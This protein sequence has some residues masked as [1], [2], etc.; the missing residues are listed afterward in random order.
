VTGVQP[1]VGLTARRALQSWL[2]VRVVTQG[3]AMTAALGTVLAACT[4]PRPAVTSRAATVA[5]SRPVSPASTIPAAVSAVL[6]DQLTVTFTSLTPAGDDLGAWLT[7]EAGIDN[8]SAHHQHL[9]AIGIRCTG[10]PTLGGHRAVASTLSLAGSLPAHSTRHGTLFLL[11]PGDRRRGR[12]V[13]ACQAPA[14]IQVSELPPT[15]HVPSLA[16]IAIPDQT[17]ATLNATRNK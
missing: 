6:P 9:P 7:A 14:I 10:S 4:S 15:P 1:A 3:V 2:A 8:H 16:R 13:P 11:L 17:L 12:G 5:A